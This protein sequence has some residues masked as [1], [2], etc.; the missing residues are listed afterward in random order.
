M[1]RAKDYICKLTEMPMSITSN[2]EAF[3]YWVSINPSQY[4][5]NQEYVVTLD[6]EDWCYEIWVLLKTN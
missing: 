3:N 5:S 1:F 2:R 4:D 6:Q